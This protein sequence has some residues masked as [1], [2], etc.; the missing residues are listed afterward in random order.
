MRKEAKECI[1]YYLKN[2]K[3][4]EYKKQKKKAILKGKRIIENISKKKSQNGKA[5]Q[6]IM[7]IQ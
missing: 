1:K 6:I 3:S 2:I 5:E 4:D 7:R